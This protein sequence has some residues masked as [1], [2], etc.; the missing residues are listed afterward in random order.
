A[1]AVTQLPAVLGGDRWKPV[2]ALSGS[3]LDAVTRAPDGTLLA[4]GDALYVSRDGLIWV[5]I[6][7]PASIAAT[8]G[9]DESPADQ[10]GH[11]HGR[12]A[13]TPIAAMA[14]AG[15]EVFLGTAQGL[16]V[17]AFDGPMRRLAFPAGGVRGLAG[18]PADRA[19]WATSAS[20]PLVST[21]GGRTWSAQ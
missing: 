10:G 11:Q 3:Y 4:A 6:D 21:D 2:E 13:P 5:R 12:A 16:F 20:G 9:T 18:D 14:V 17:S 7:L 15:S 1:P 8:P 19:L